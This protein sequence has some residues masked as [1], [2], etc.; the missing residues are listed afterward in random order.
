MLQIFN[1]SFFFFNEG[2]KAELS[3]AATGRDV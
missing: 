2:H 3:L 1:F